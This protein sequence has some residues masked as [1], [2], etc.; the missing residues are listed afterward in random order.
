VVDKSAPVRSMADYEYV[1]QPA[2]P[3]ILELLAYW[4][5]RRGARFAP[6]RA[7]IDPADIV[8]LLPDLMMV[9]VI[10][11][12]R[13]FRFR[14]IGTRIVEGLGRDST[15]RLFSELYANQPAA[16]QRLGDR[17]Q[18]V[19]KLRRPVF[20]RGQLYWVPERG[21]KRFDSAHLPLSNDGASVDIVLAALII[22]RAE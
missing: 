1:D 16:R 4:N 2:A 20:S 8:A 13:D 15:G 7:D 6:T 12:G 21:H 10:D 9:D 11:A 14:L 17:F 18:Q 19:I 22:S 3:A 5:A